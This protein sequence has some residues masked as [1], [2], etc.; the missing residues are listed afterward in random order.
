M[1][2]LH[3]HGDGGRRRLGWRA[4]AGGLRGHQGQQDGAAG[5]GRAPAIALMCGRYN[6]LTSREAYRAVY[7]AMRKA[8][9]NFPPRYNIAPTD[10]A[11]LE[12]LSCTPSKLSEESW[13][14]KAAASGCW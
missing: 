7:K 1:A 11:S 13:I 6:N 12:S 5:D 14:V 9:W 4:G 10:K 3:R 8:D 2:A